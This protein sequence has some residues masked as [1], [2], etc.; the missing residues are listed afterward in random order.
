MYQIALR[1][2]SPVRY[3]APLA[4]TYWKSALPEAYEGAI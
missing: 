3:D 4:T 2:L 1:A